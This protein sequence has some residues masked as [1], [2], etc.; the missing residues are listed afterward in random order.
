MCGRYEPRAPGFIGLML[1][2]YAESISHQARRTI[3]SQ[4]TSVIGP[5][6]ER[7]SASELSTIVVKIR[8][9]GDNNL[10]GNYPLGLVD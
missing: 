9:T 2:I 8:P 10:G 4:T 6:G 5:H 3:I 7:P 1:A